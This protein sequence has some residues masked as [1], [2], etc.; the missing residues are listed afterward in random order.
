MQL[1]AHKLEVGAKLDVL[2][3]APAPGLLPG[4]HYPY[5]RAQPLFSSSGKAI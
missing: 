4:V 1:D 3:R 5:D 2:S